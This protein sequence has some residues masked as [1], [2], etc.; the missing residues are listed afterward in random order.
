M[1]L[2]IL[3]QKLGSRKFLLTLVGI[4]AY[5]TLGI[6]GE[7]DWSIVVEKSKTVF[8]GWLIVEGF[9]DAARVFGKT[10]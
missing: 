1:N 10:E 6:A 8:V 3:K 5:I 4:L 2:T 7:M 9:I